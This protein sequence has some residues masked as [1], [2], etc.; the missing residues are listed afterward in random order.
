MSRNIKAQAENIEELAEMNKLATFHRRELKLIEDRQKLLKALI[1]KA[2]G[3]SKFGA[4]DGVDVVEIV[5]G[6]R[7]TTNIDLVLKFAPEKADVLIEEKPTKNVK[8]L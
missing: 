1:F 7:K 4:I 8:I 3:N 5:H 2:C 6:T